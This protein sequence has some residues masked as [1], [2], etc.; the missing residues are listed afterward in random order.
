MSIAVYRGVKYDTDKEFHTEHE[1]RK[2]N[3]TYRGTRHTETIKVEV[4]K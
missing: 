1:Y 4:K 2:V 3:E